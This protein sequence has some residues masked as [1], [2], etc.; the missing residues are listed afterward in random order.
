[1]K[2]VRYTVCDCENGNVVPVALI[3]DDN[4]FFLRV[5]T[6]ILERHGFEVLIAEDGEEGHAVF[7]DHLSRIDI[8]ITDL[9][10]PKLSGTELC[11]RIKKERPEVP[12]VLVTASDGVRNNLHPDFELVLQKPLEPDFMER[13]KGL[14]YDAQD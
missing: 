14:I 13:V 5:E 9:M 12:V 8:V 2:V 4:P 11:K 7:H 6:L 1:M 3:V 10:L